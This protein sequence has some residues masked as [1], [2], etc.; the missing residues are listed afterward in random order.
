MTA[1]SP[2]FW[3]ATCGTPRGRSSPIWRCPTKLPPAHCATPRWRRPKR[4]FCRLSAR[5]RLSGTS[6]QPA[7]RLG[8]SADH[9][10]FWN[11]RPARPFGARRQRPHRASGWCPALP[12]I[13]PATASAAAAAIMIAPCAPRRQRTA[14]SA[15]PTASSCVRTCRPMPWIGHLSLWQPPTNWWLPRYHIK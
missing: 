12:L 3:P 1:S 5:A 6:R 10:A 14:P 9:S 2:A 8:L 4:W 15:S 13:A 11:R 7:T